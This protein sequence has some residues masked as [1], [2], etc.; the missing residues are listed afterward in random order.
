[1]SYPSRMSSPELNLD[2]APSA[3]QSE[4]GPAASASSDPGVPST[5]H[6]GPRRSG[7]SVGRLAL[8]ALLVAAVAA[9]AWLA[10]RP[11]KSADNA[12]AAAPDRKALDRAWENLSDENRQA[13]IAYLLPSEEEVKGLFNIV[14]EADFIR[15][16]A[17]HAEL[18]P[19]I[20]FYFLPENDV[21]NAV[22]MPADPVQKTETPCVV[23]FGG[24]TRMAR[25]VGAAVAAKSFGTSFGVDPESRMLE[26]LP[27][28][29]NRSMGKLIAEEA[30]ALL[31]DCGIRPSLFLDRR[32]LVE[33]VNVADGDCLACIGHEVGHIAYHHLDGPG[34]ESEETQRNKEREADSFAMSIAREER[35]YMD[36]KVEQYMFIGSVYENYIFALMEA[37]NGRGGDDRFLDHPC[38]SERLLNLL[39]SKTEL[40]ELYGLSVSAVEQALQTATASSKR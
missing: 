38:S 13:I 17:A 14:K 33:A 12:E 23:L 22:S 36:G 32:F 34:D 3:R 19:S 31:K 7:L 11:G 4:S 18:M 2:H 15:K 35:Q 27:R 26:L 40:S 6:Q 39:R 16:N 9:G 1:M 28:S 20:S 8:C 5:R 29:L 10:L 25:V 37:R 21:V 24:W 30:F